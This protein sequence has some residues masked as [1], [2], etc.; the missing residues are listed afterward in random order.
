MVD[1]VHALADADLRGE[2][3]N[4]VHALQRAGDGRLVSNVTL[5]EVDVAVDEIGLRPV[6][7]NLLDEAVEDPDPIVSPKQLRR[8]V[9]PDEAGTSGN[10]N[11]LDQSSIP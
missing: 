11:G 7:V 6:D 4:G 3:H 8:E 9:A 10:Q 5:D 1:G 2:M